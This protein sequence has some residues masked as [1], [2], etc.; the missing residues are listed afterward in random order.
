MNKSKIIILD[1]GMYSH[2]AIF[3]SKNNPK[4]PVEYTCLS[5]IL[6]SLRRI[7][8]EPMDKIIV[9]C[10]GQNNW[11]KEV[12]KNYKA[13]R[14][15]L[16]EKSGIDFAKM[17]GRMDA[18]LTK[19]DDGTEWYVIK[20]NKLEADDIASVACRYY[21][22]NEVVLV[23][24]DSDWEMLTLYP[25]V[26]V[27]SP[28]IKFK[29]GKGAYKVIKQD[30]YIILSKKIEKETSDNLISPILT[31]KDYENR[32][33]IVS[34]LE[35]PDFVENACIERFQQLKPKEENLAYVPFENIRKKIAGLF[36]DKE[37]VVTYQDC[38]ERANKKKEK[39]KRR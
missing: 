22:D 34:L 26:K 23:S 18:L 12:D 28:L 16:R 5:M 13:N 15:G 4:I 19:I 21:K 11:R 20:I 10:D 38:V 3:A 27:F 31:E 33:M 1:F 17:Y 9:A 25:N 30:P 24:F 37:K 36:N 7:G 35:L 8:V 39:K 2:R 14:A 6:A 29:G 32:K